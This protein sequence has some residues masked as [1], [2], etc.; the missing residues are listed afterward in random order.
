[1]EALF[2]RKKNQLWEHGVWFDQ[3]N[4]FHSTE[5]HARFLRKMLYTSTWI[6]IDNY[7]E[8]TWRCKYTLGKLA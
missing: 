5:V 3:M 1:M 2:K 8:S 7:V 6:D 4:P